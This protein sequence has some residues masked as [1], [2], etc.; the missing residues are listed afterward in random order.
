M[1]KPEKEQK[2]SSKPQGLGQQEIKNFYFQVAK[3]IN[4]IRLKKK[5]SV[6]KLS[7]LTHIETSYIYRIEKGVRNLGVVHL[8]LIAKSFGVSMDDFMPEDTENK[9]MTEIKNILYECSHREL[10]EIQ[11]YLE[12]NYG[13]EK[14]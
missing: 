11:S 4:T 5:I 7:T 12:E 13:N 1:L 3:C 14:M 2:K 10:K 6:Y 8:Y 9:N